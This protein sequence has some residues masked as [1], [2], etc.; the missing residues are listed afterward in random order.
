[1]PS[2]PFKNIQLSLRH[3]AKPLAARRPKVPPATSYTFALFSIKNIHFYFFFLFFFF[4]LLPRLILLPLPILLLPI[5]VWHVH[6]DFP[7]WDAGDIM[8]NFNA[9]WFEPHIGL[10]LP[11]TQGAR[12]TGSLKP[13][14][15]FPSSF[16]LSPPLFPFSFP[17]PPCRGARRPRS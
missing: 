15:F 2:S 8:F 16:P 9:S 4:S 7:I 5:H 12:V 11:I 13:F 10:G 14:F 17:P 3:P 6:V 1:L